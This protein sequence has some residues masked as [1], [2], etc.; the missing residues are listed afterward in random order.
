MIQYVLSIFTILDWWASSCIHPWVRFVNTT[1]SSL[2]QAQLHIFIFS[3]P[4]GSLPGR[5]WSRIIPLLVSDFASSSH[6]SCLTNLWHLLLKG[7]FSFPPFSLS[8]LVE[9]TRTL[10]NYWCVTGSHPH[11]SS[12]NNVGNSKGS[13]IFPTWVVLSGEGCYYV[14]IMLLSHS[15]SKGML[16]LDE[17]LCFCSFPIHLSIRDQLI[18]P[19]LD[20]GLIL[21]LPLIP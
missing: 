14:I 2:L 7:C 16:C 21:Y 9:N 3:W 17:L 5:P 12:W 1:I 10:F 13:W 15:N 6:M 8:H 20:L 19:V 11:P 18:F 4:C